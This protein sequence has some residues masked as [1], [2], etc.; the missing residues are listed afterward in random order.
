MVEEEEE[1]E[2]EGWLRLLE[3]RDEAMKK[4]VEVGHP[5][6]HVFIPPIQPIHLC[7][8]YT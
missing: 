5:P 1:E 3:G 7:N 6:T 2:E 8:P 4:E